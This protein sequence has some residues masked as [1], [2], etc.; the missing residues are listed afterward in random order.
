MMKKWAFAYGMM[1]T[2]L[3][4]LLAVSYM[5]ADNVVSTDTFVL[6]GAILLNSW[7]IVSV[8]VDVSDKLLVHWAST[9]Q[10]PQ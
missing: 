8:I 9:S 2:N 5:A 10:H 6:C 4:Y 3:I 7:T 1:L